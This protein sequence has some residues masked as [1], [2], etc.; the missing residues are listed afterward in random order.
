[1]AVVAA[2]LWY[3][4]CQQYERKLISFEVPKCEKAFLL[5]FHALLH[6]SSCFYTAPQ[7]IGT[8]VW[9]SLSPSVRLSVWRCIVG[10]LVG[11]NSIDLLP[12]KLSERMDGWI[13][14]TVHCIVSSH[15]FTFRN[16]S[17]WGFFVACFIGSVF[18][19][20]DLSW[21]GLVACFLSIHSLNSRWH[22]LTTNIKSICW[23]M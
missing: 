16:T 6:I 4:K 5:F 15:S 21:L 2:M 3:F 18:F 1:M 20:L 7:N 14:A 8:C 11:G 23:F 13:D 17:W 12:Q 10:W 22:L 19:F 9:T